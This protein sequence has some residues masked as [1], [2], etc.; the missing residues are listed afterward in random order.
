MDSRPV[1]VKIDRY[2][3]VVSIVTA[4]RKKLDEAKDTL[5]KINNFKNEEDHQVE[6]WQNSLGEIEKKIEFIENALG[7][8]E[9][10]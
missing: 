3:E 2:N 4:L 7:Q 10:I 1:F 6:L 9:S 5:L 8:P